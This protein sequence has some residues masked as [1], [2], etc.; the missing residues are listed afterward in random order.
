MKAK[1]ILMSRLSISQFLVENLKMLGA[2]P[3]SFRNDYCATSC[4]RLAKSAR[5]R[6]SCLLHRVS[7]CFL[8]GRRLR[9]AL[10]LRCRRCVSR[11][12]VLHVFFVVRSSNPSAAPFPIC[13]HDGYIN[14][15][16]GLTRGPTGS[17]LTR[18][19]Q[20]RFHDI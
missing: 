11:L 18:A 19:T 10:Q 14:I 12:G 20:T 7:H 15:G 3:N 1:P 2:D 17:W 8:C 16:I 4:L 9:A 5:R 13:Q 6:C